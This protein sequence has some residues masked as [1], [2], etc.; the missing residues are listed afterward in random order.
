MYT[1]INPILTGILVSGYW[2]ETRAKRAGSLRFSTLFE[3]F[4]FFL[5]DLAPLD[6]LSKFA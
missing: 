3:F 4:F 6:I 2:E 1:I 5:E